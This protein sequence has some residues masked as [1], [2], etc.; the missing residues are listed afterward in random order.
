MHNKRSFPR[1][2]CIVVVRHM[3]LTFM[4]MGLIIYLHLKY[5]LVA[6]NVKK[7]TFVLRLYHHSYCVLLKI[8]FY[9]FKTFRHFSICNH[10][11]KKQNLICLTGP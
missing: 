8:M 11:I 6:V 2:L 5:K 10:G 1:Q 7:T 4:A 9:T 3:T